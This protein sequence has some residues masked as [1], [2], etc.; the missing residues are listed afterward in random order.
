MAPETEARAT[1]KS[2]LQATFTVDGFTVQ[3]DHLHESLGI[4]GTRIG[5]SPVRTVPSSRDNSVAEM[6]ILVQF[7]GKWNPRID[8][9][10]SVDPA[11][12]EGF[13]DR[14]RKALRTGDPNTDGVWYF[15]LQSITYP[16]DPTGNKTR[17]EATVIARGNNT[18]L[19]ET[20]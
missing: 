16:E 17:F 5:T 8:P 4:E 3:D 20:T 1:L 13:A 7:Y 10:Q 2:I 18:A 6:F 11:T 14:F 9:N 19:L 15:A 12:I